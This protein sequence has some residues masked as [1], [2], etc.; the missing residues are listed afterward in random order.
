MSLL[1]IE[2]LHLYYGGIHALKGVTLRVD[3]GERVALIG[4]NGAGKTSCL[5]A[6]AGLLPATGQLQ[7]RN[8]NLLRLAAFE[9][10][11]QGLVLVPEGR[12]IFAD[13]SVEENLLLGAFHRKDREIGADLNRLYQDFPRLDERRQQAAG[14]LSGGEQ[15]LLALA[16]ALMA[17]PRLLLLDEPSMG[18]APIMVQQV[19]ECLNRISQAGI[20]LLLVEQNAQLALKFSHRAYVL[21]QGQICL[22]GAAS[23]L[24]QN[25]QVQAAYLGA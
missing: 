25:P 10:P 16:R 8:Q 20:T 5:K 12:G 4:A 19:F 6:I 11:A 13:L 9:R 15:Q 7:Y 21:E 3:D 22:Q 2:Q 14:T 1:A 23:E 18:L 17:R 24:L